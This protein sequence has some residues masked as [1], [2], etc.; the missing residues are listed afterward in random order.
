MARPVIVDSRGNPIAREVSR[1]SLRAKY[2]AAQSTEETSRHWAWSDSLSAKSAN[3]AAVRLKLRTRA[4]YEIANNSYAS[5][6]VST[7]ANDL[8][9]TGPRLQLL[10]ENDEFN[11]ATETDFTA[12]SRA[13][14]LAGK[15]QTLT[16]SKV[17]DGEG[18]GLL[19]TNPRL[20][21]AVK[22]DV[23]LYE[24]DQVATPYAYIPDALSVDGIRFDRDGNVIEYHLLRS[25]P[26][27]SLSWPGGME[28]DAIP[29]DRMIHW[30]RV[31]RPGQ[32]RGVPDITP[33]LNLFAQLRRYTLAV[34]AAAETAADFAAVLGTELPPDSD[35]DEI[36][37]FTSTPIERRMMTTLPAG[38][39]LSQLKAEQPTTTYKEF[40]AEIL[41]EI[42]RCLNMPFN[43]AAG[44]SSS[45]NYSSGRLD[46]QVYYRNL[47]VERA[48]LERVALDPIFA[49]WLRESGMRAG[50]EYGEM[51]H[52][53]LWPGMGHV[54]PEKEAN[55]TATL[56]QNLLTTFSDEC[57]KQGVDPESRAATIA[58]DIKLF[59]S[60]GLPNPYQAKQPAAPAGPGSPTNGQ[61]ANRDQGDGEDAA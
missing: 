27:D 12:W 20:P 37:P 18:F 1:G 8:I 56:L 53:W 6:I 19:T 10:T 13:A 24:A 3:D 33:A 55:A 35:E 51:P 9:G 29:A 32:W 59:E 17:G 60:Y 26:G 36:E 14:C 34:L 4:R 15:L 38:Y 23:R 41:N 39:T 58:A 31:D 7:L 42:A 54:D 43:V 28:Y 61:P 57:Q 52:R 21:A 50:A 30:F 44:N 11:R 49:A 25:H 48:H 46:H 47:D 45:Y 22:L 16:R 2:D 5:G 40:K